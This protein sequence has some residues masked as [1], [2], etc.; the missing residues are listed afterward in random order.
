MHLRTLDTPSVR[1][2][3]KPADPKA[4]LAQAQKRAPVSVTPPGEITVSEG[5]KTYA[6]SIKAGRNALLFITAVL[7]G[8][9]GMGMGLRNDLMNRERETLK[10]VEQEPGKKWADLT[11]I[12]SENALKRMDSEMFW[13]KV[14]LAFVLLAFGGLALAGTR[15]YKQLM[16]KAKQSDMVNMTVK[17]QS[18]PLSQ[19]LCEVLNRRIDQ[20][21]ELYATQ[22]HTL[23]REK[24]EAR[25]ELDSIFG[26]PD[27]LPTAPD[28][29]KLFEYTTYQK[30]LHEHHLTGWEGTPP[31]TEQEHL[32]KLYTLLRTGLILGDPFAMVAE[33]PGTVTGQGFN[34]ELLS[35]VMLTELT[36]QEETRHLSQLVEKKLDIE[37]HLTFARKA[38]TVASLSVVNRKEEIQQIES[39]LAVFN[40]Y[41]AQLEA[42][43][44]QPLTREAIQPKAHETLLAGVDESL[45]ETLLQLKAT[46]LT[47]TGE[48]TFQTSLQQALGT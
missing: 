26:G 29:R 21:C 15:S 31:V 37:K 32:E 48:Q 23:Y 12:S 34:D 19:G 41:N 27:S 46:L 16:Q 6:Q 36:V 44:N 45:A 9:I 10:Q 38:L 1:F 35:Q 11:R 40:Q 13:L 7:S 39:A 14:E 43:L 8:M 20:A 28:L 25:A 2:S 30:V 5:L 24:P 3:A 22:F 33:K 18:D 17:A 47:H 4:T 42:A